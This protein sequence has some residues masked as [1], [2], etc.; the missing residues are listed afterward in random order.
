MA[1]DEPPLMSLYQKNLKI[2][3]TEKKR[4]SFTEPIVCISIAMYDNFYCLPAAT[5]DPVAEIF[6]TC[7]S[8]FSVDIVMTYML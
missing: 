5:E 2:F 3:V 8:A 4:S 7:Y 1:S 6:I